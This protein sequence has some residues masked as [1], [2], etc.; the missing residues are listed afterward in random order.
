MTAD[1][2]TEQGTTRSY[3]VYEESAFILNVQTGKLRLRNI[4]RRHQAET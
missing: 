4:Q 1:T 3:Q 2:L